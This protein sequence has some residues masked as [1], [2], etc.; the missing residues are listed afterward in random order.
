MHIWY[1]TLTWLFFALIATWRQIELLA[2]CRC[3][4]EV[5]HPVPVLIVDWL[6]YPLPQLGSFRDVLTFFPWSLI[7]RI[8]SSKS[9]CTCRYNH[10]AQAWM[11]TAT[12]HTGITWLKYSGPLFYWRQLLWPAS[13]EHLCPEQCSCPWLCS[14]S[15]PC[16]YLRLQYVHAPIQCCINMKIGIGMRLTQRPSKNRIL[17]VVK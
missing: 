14:C 9:T 3:S 5:V 10:I 13:P 11:A 17:D 6:H 12:L 7:R 4:C 15:H 1:C 2:C 16:P 8:Q